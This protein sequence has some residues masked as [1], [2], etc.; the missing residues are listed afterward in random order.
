MAILSGPRVRHS[1]AFTPR[2]EEG[3]PELEAF[4]AALTA[5]GGIEGVE[6]LE[7][8]REVSPKNGYRFG[9][10][11]E[12]ADG[13]AYDAYNNHPDHVAFVR[14]HWAS[15]VVDFL[16]IDFAALRVS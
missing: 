7:V 3:T 10:V 6:R 16:E 15:E 11:M 8:V 12:F 13:D 14:D 5:L 2:H 4:L 1:V 9:V